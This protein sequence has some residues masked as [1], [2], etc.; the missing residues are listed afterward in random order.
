L[1]D[2]DLDFGEDKPEDNQNGHILNPASLDELPKS[3]RI[4][5][6]RQGQNAPKGV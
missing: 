1:E 6:N 2:E 4:S 5:G 3:W